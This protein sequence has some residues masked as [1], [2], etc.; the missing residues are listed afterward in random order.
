VRRRGLAA[1]LLVLL[2][3]AGHAQW[4][5]IREGRYAPRF[6]PATLPDR[7][8]TICR[9]MYESERWEPL[10]MGWRTDYPYAERNLMVRLAELTRTHVSF[11]ARQQPNHYVVRLTDDALFQCPFTVASDVGTISLTDDEAARL[12][13][14]LLKGGFLWVD[15]FWGPEAWAHWQRQLARV[16]PPSEYP[17][18]EVPLSDPVFQALYTIPGVP[19][20]PSLQFWRRSGRGSTSERGPDSPQAELRALRDLSGRI[21]VVMTHNT[22]IADSWEREGEDLDFFSRFSADGYALGIDV[23]L[24]ALS[25]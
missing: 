21:L 23:V 3:A 8:F 11:D 10:G 19:Q 5:G 6:A 16:L 17:I 15:D 9:L 22:D 20:I 2:A 18:V 14:Y 7:A 4:G 25:H 1:A 13:A 12:R 24:H